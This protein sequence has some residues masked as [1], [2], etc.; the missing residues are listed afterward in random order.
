MLLWVWV[1]LPLVQT[2]VPGDK[3]IKSHVNGESLLTDPDDVVH[4]QIT[5]LVQHH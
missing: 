2:E 4:T 5:Q 1:S 3:V